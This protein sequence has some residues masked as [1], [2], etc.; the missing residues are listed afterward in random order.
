MQGA[1]CACTIVILIMLGQHPTLKKTQYTGYNNL[2]QSFNL[3][4]L[5]TKTL[6]LVDK[7]GGRICTSATRACNA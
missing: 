1:L 4:Q 7:R 3:R 2:F 5:T 6:L